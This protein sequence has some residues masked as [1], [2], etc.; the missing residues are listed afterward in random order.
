MLKNGT[1]C[2]LL[3]GNFDICVNEIAYALS[4]PFLYRSFILLSIARVPSLRHKID[5]L[6]LYIIHQQKEIDELKKKVK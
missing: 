5:E 6:T 3:I 4:R 1:F 2:V